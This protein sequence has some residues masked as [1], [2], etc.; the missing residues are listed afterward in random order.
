MRPN[1]DPGKLLTAGLPTP[2]R[3]LE[4]QTRS[5]LIRALEEACELEHALLVQYLFAAFAIRTRPEEKISPLQAEYGRRWKRSIL[6]V[7]REE[8]MHL[9]LAANLLAAVGGEAWLR[10]VDLPAPNRYFPHEEEFALFTL[11]ALD[12][13]TIAR[14]VRFEQPYERPDEPARKDLAPV[15]E[16]A[17]V[18]ELYRKIEDYIESHSQAELFIG[19]PRRQETD[20]WGNP[21]FHIEPV[22]DAVSAI[23]AIDRIVAEGEGTPA[24]TP[25]SH[26]GRFLAIQGELGRAGPG[27]VKDVGPN[28]YLA[29]RTPE[30][31][32]V[33]PLTDEGAIALARLFNRIYFSSLLMLELLYRFPP[34]L[35]PARDGVRDQVRRAMSGLLRPLGELLTELPAGHSA[36]PRA[37]PTFELEE[38][39]HLA[40]DPRSALTAVEERLREDAIAATGLLEG[41]LRARPHFASNVE[42][43]AEGVALAANRVGG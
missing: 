32:A 37:G 17:T 8:M 9:A 19:A 14:F 42:L 13:E 39:I 10:R 27:V 31:D 34:G 26:Y 20:G 29:G 11:R 30:G 3:P 33:T 24:A 23:R 25:E 43:L 36:G 40:P 7:A 41:A 1:G 12:A 18:G 28:P 38:S 2:P 15:V 22:T 21:W 6:R 5:E 35:R 4:I 16:H